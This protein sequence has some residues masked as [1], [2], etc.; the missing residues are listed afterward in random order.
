[1]GYK[2]LSRS[3]KKRLRKSKKNHSKVVGLLQKS[4]NNRFRVKVLSREKTYKISVRE[5][6]K[7][8]IGDKVLCSLSP[9]GWAIIE[10]VLESNTY[11]FIGR[12]E[13][14]GKSYKASPLDSGKYNYVNIIGKLPKNLK[15]Y[16]M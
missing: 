8:F 2:P 1:M 9:I 6:K 13:K 3:R 14:F 4:K 11:R 16:K 12:I 5:L 15:P 7:A 10:K